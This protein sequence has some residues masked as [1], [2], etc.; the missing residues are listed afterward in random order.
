MFRCW[1]LPA[2]VSSMLADVH[3]GKLDLTPLTHTAGI[4]QAMR[5][6]EFHHCHAG[7]RWTVHSR[8][9]NTANGCE[10]PAI[11]IQ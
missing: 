8:V 7:C 11:I 6:F 2:C 4:H 9:T 1:P 5:C 10:P 3:V